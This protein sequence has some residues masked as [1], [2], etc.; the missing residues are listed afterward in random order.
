MIISDIYKRSLY[1]TFIMASIAMIVLATSITILYNV[2]FQEERQRL[3]ETAQSHAR[4]MEAI[5]LHDLEELGAI[6]LESTLDQ[7]TE[8]HEQF[9]GFGDTGEF[10][11]AKLANNQIVFLLS[12]RHHDLT[13]PHPVSFNG[14]E[15]EPM[16]FALQGKSGSLVGLDYRG[17]TVLAAHEPVAHLNLGVVAKIDLKEIRAPFVLAGWITFSIALFFVFIGSWAFQRITKPIQAEMQDKSER[18]EIAIN[19]TNDGLWLWDIITD[20]E[21]HAPQ[22]KRLLGYEEDEPLPERYST[23]ESRIHLDDKEQVLNMLKQHLED[24]TPYDSEHRL[25]TKSGEYIWIRDRGMAIRDDS[26][27]A[28]RMGGSIQDISDL[29]IAES[30]LK[31][32]HNEL[33]NRNGE[34][35][36]AMATIKTISGIIP[37]CAWCSN[38]IKDDGEW[39]KLE[40]YFEGHTDAH[41]SHGMCPTCVEKHSKS[42]KPKS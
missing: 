14:K 29:K 33:E 21:W 22:W 1:L 12:H 27:N 19:G 40:T 38:Q 30:K 5:A 17:E 28:V 10:T 42:N 16:R 34:L 6:N 11:L 41:F 9:E 37:I 3:I 32:S 39:I 36:K 8:A 23:W 13:N 31:E 2:G 35:K 7:I 25:R 4:L 24:N 15:A 26:G 18:L 20:Y